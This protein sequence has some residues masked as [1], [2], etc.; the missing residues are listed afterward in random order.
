[1]FTQQFFSR[2]NHADLQDDLEKALEKEIDKTQSYHEDDLE[3]ALEKEIDKMQSDQEDLEDDIETALEKEIDM[4]GSTEARSA[5]FPAGTAATSQPLRLQAKQVPTAELDEPVEP[6]P[7]I[8]VVGGG[9]MA[10]CTDAKE[11]PSPKS[12]EKSPQKE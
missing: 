10:D 5:Y 12:A 1:M 3:K 11:R 8:R 9:M 6:V 7:S 2:R 4:D